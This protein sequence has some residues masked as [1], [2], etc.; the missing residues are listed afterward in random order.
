MVL[1]IIT[2]QYESI[3]SINLSIKEYPDKIKPY[4]SDMI[5]NHKAQGNK[6]GE[7]IQAIQ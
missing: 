4:L 6:N 2:V 3:G 1:L 5:N 7:F